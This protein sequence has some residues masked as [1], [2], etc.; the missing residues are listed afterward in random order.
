M[1]EVVDAVVIGAGP[2]GLAG[3]NVLA[4]AGWDVVV[5]E[6]QATPGGAVR[7]EELTEPGFHHD[8]F[9][10]FYPLGAA[11]PT[12]RD[13]ALEDHGV[14]WR[15][16]EAVVAHAFDAERAAV[17]WQDPA[18]TAASVAAFAPGDRDAW[19]RWSAWWERVGGVLLDGLMRPFPPLRA[20][21]R[22]ATK[23]GPLGLLALGRL[24]VLPLRRHVG[25]EFAGEGAALLLAGNALHADFTPETPG[26]SIYAWTLAGLGQQVGFPVPEGGAARLIDALVARLRA[27][28][29]DLRCGEEAVRIDARTRTVHCAGGMA[30]RARRAVLAATSAPAL[31]TRLLADAELPARVREGI[32]RFEWDPGTVKVDWAL[33]DEIPWAVQDVRRAGTVHVADGLDHL[34]AWASDIQRG[35]VPERPFLVMGQYARLDPTRMPPGKEV[36]WAYTHL[37]HGVASPDGLADAIEAEI[38]RRAPGFRALI[39]ARHVLTPPDMEA[40]DANLVGGAL[41]GGTAQLHQQLVLRPVPGLGRAETPV[42]GVYLASAGAHPGGG[43]HGAAGT[44]AARAALARARLARR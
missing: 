34:T 13:L 6:A 32:A 17:L 8:V 40:R 28:G 20:G 23:L 12:M 21:A 39:R 18:R 35:R 2:N 7:T 14:T 44:N 5:L 30:I 37:P 15:R 22:L 31:Y 38:E 19:L 24:G 25:E 11:A 29:G 26:G 1:T 16:S 4:A 27:H 33:D 41:N 9:S 36:A 42:R 10:S 43:V 3:A